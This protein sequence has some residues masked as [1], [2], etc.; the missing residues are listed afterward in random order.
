MASSTTR[1]PRLPRNPAGRHITECATEDPCAG[2][3]FAL[4]QLA[5]GLG[6]VPYGIEL[7][8]DRAEIMRD[9]LPD[10]QTLRPNPKGP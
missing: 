8:E 7:S 3:G 4:L 9:L 5:E 2:A 10:D 6:A 1:L